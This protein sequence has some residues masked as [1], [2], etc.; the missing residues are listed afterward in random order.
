MTNPQRIDILDQGL[1]GG[2]D[3]ALPWTVVQEDGVTAQNITGWSIRWRLFRFRD[4][5]AA[6]VTKTVGSGI[7]ITNGPTGAYT[8][9]LTP[10]D[11]TVTNGDYWYRS[12][13]TDS[14]AVTT[15]QE[16]YLRIGGWSKATVAQPGTFTY[17]PLSGATRDAVRAALGDTDGTYRQLSNEELDLLVAQNGGSRDTTIAAATQLAIRFS[18]L[19]DRQVGDLKISYAGRAAD[20]RALIKDLQSLRGASLPIA[21][22]GGISKADRLAVSEDG[23]RVVPVFGIGMN[24][25]P[26]DNVGQLDDRGLSPL[27]SEG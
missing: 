8:V 15:V 20:L 27:V 5:V 25:F 9:T 23:D 22:A 11:L 6:L 7:A 26:N 4:S 13:R 1:Y 21:Y 2:E 3:K 10:T 14:G 12:E 19:A 16:G 18:Q 24:D 17:D